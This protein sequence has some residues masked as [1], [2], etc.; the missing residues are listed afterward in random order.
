MEDPARMR[1]PG[2]MEDLVPMGHPDRTECPALRESQDRTQVPDRMQ[3]AG[4]RAP[5]GR[6]RPRAP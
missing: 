1:P 4:R 2:L 3:Q 6:T 5:R